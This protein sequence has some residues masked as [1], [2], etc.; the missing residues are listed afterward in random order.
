M[1]KSLMGVLAALPLFAAAPAV[2]CEE[3]AKQSEHAKHGEHSAHGGTAKAAAPTQKPTS[4]PAAKNGLQTVALTVTSKGFEPANVKVKAGQP[5]RL[6][7]TRKTDKTCAT[8]IVVADLGIN[9][10]LPLDT[11]VTVEFTPSESGTL[12]YACAMDHISGLVTIQ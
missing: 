9:Q 5:V 4:A 3:H 12:R 7:V 1:K 10:P 2:A 6:V 11:P 8:E